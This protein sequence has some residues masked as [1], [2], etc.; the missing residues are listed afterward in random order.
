VR[1]VSLTDATPE[2]ELVRV[3]RGRPN[4]WR[5]VLWAVRP[6]DPTRPLR[7]QSVGATLT[8]EQARHPSRELA[9]LAAVA[10]RWQDAGPFAH[11]R[12]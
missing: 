4:D 1:D 6:D 5:V 12:V 8:P 9:R 11:P 10:E 2:C 3:E 7:D